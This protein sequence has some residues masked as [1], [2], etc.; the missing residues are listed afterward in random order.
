MLYY[1]CF[2]VV[3]VV[4]VIITYCYCCCYSTPIHLAARNGHVDIVESLVKKFKND[5]VVVVI[6]IIFVAVI[7]VLKNIC[8]IIYL[9]VLLEKFEKN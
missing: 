6:I 1:C 2:V 5:V 7:V 3:I 4:I 8:Y 9:C